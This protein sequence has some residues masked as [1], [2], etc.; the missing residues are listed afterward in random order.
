MYR[1]ILGGSGSG[2]TKKA[3][4]DCISAA[5]ADEGSHFLL[6]VPEQSTTAA[7]KE[8]VRLHECHATDNIDVLSFNRLAYKVFDELD[9]VNPMVLDDISKAMILRK[10]GSEHREELKVWSSRFDKPGFIDN[11]KSM[12]SELYLYGISPEDIRSRMPFSD[13]QLQNKMYDLC[14]IYEAFRNY[15]S[16]RYVALEEI[17]DILASNIHNSSLIRN[18]TIILDGFTGFT[19]VQYRIIENFLC[20]AKEVVIT[21]GIGDDRDSSLFDMSRD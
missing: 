13:R 20:S 16:G 1:F 10:M 17:P 21:V 18:S 12:I 19:P 14:I 3:Y 6:I 2:K 7:E 9:I 4:S 15:I 5:M 8:I 11:L